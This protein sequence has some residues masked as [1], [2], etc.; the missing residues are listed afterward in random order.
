MQSEKVKLEELIIKYLNGSC[1]PEEERLLLSWTN[2]LDLA[3]D[4]T[5]DENAG[6]LLKHRIDKAN[7]MG[8]RSKLISLFKPLHYAAASILLVAIGGLT[9]YL[10]YHSGQKYKAQ[11]SLTRVTFSQH[12]EKLINNG[13]S[14]ARF[15]LEDGSEVSLQAKSSLVWQVPFA[16]HIRKVELSG[17]AFFQVAKN[18]KKPFVV[19]S[20]NISTTALGTSFWVSEHFGK[21]EV[22]VQLITGKVVVK[23]FNGELSNTLAYLT[24]GQQLTY[25]LSNNSAIVINTPKT[26]VKK[27]SVKTIAQ[28]PLIFDSTPLTEV[29]VSLQSYYH[30][31]IVCQAKRVE[32]MTFYGAYSEK[33]SIET[34]LNTITAAN[35][36]KVRKL[37]NTFIISD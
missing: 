9:W 15:K 27:P 18:K 32:A 16:N 19:F 10:S 7:G 33:D 5:I 37:N 6:A 8:K 25:K 1:S 26:G 4:V 31:K 36:L 30:I 11:N 17:K 29:F 21:K 2:Q 14:A 28:P 34:I 35:G 3:G 20:G 13:K 12:F 22:E 23:H 24:P